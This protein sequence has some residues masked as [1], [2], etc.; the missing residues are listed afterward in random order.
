MAKYRPMTVPKRASMV[1]R[2]LPAWVGETSRPSVKA[3]TMTSGTSCKGLQ[4]RL[5]VLRARVHA[6]VGDE[7]DQVDALGARD[8]LGQAL[9]E[10]AVG[11]GL[12][13]AHQ[14][15]LDDGA[16]AEVEVADLRVAHLPGRQAD[17]LAAGGQGRRVVGLPQLVEDGGVGER[18]GVAR[19]RLREAVAVEDDERDRY[20]LGQPQAAMMAAKDS[21]SSEAPPTRKPSMSGWAMS[22]PALSGLADP[23]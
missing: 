4:Q 9:T 17:G 20:P 5:E 6:A 10:R 16:G 14:V 18:D 23:P 7:A 13:D 19:A 12:V 22:S 3:W 8:R 2:N 15:L 1:S 11:D 21:G